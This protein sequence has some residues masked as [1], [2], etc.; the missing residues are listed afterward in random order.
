[1]RRWARVTMVVALALLA[2]TSAQAAGAPE[3]DAGFHLLYE[4]NF[5]Q[6]R[7]RFRTWQ[8]ANPTD[9]LGYAAE[10]AGFLFEEFYRQDVFT[11]TF[12]LDDK[13]LLEGVAHPPNPQ[14]RA[15]FMASNQRARE[16]ARQQ[17]RGNPRDADALFALT[18][19]SGML[20]DYT[21]LIEKRHL[22]SLMYV[23]EAE[24][25]AEKLLDADPNLA[26]AYLALGAAHYMIG[27]LPAHKRFFLW[28]AGIRG[29]RQ[30]GMAE[31]EMTAMHGHYLRPFAKILL[32]VVFLREKQPER[33]RA[34]L[35]ELTAEFPQNPLFAREL[36]NLEKTTRHAGS[37]P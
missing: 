27:S 4:T 12:F 1:M 36:A 33:T 29:D 14:R 15:G 8:Q 9:P 3:L 25:S 31:L 18:I 35:E 26:D 28:F 6:A 2:G 37:A 5:E 19:T 34:L 7:A 16:L 22:Q 32:A 17:L 10:A 20:A 11:S 21:S 30:H 24:A 23:R 13:K